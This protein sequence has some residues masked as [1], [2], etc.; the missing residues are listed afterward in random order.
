MI[1][2]CWLGIKIARRERLNHVTNEHPTASIKNLK[3]LLV[4][5]AI[6]FTIPN[7]HIA[8]LHTRAI[9]ARFVY[10]GQVRAA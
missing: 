7:L 9:E 1:A 3:R 4:F 2:F 5:L 6:L 10:W 8:Y